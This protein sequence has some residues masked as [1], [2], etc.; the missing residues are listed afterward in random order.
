VSLVFVTLFNCPFPFLFVFNYILCNFCPI[1]SFY[2]RLF[3]NWYLFVSYFLQCFLHVILNPFVSSVCLATVYPYHCH[4]GK[5]HPVSVIRL[6]WM[7]TYT[8]LYVASWL[9]EA[10]CNAKLEYD[11]EWTSRTSIWM[12]IE[13]RPN[14]REQWSLRVSDNLYTRVR[15][16][17]SNGSSLNLTS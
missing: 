16:P 14:E 1:I 9:H 8:R 11:T 12:V 17:E 3:V 4:S 5:L 2:L 7:T 6:K 13:L 10:V 15:Q